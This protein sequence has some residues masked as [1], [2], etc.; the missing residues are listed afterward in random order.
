[1]SDT[2][3]GIS[4]IVLSMFLLNAS[5]AFI[6][7]GSDQINF[8]QLMT[9]MG[10]IGAVV[11]AGYSWANGRQPLRRE[12]IQPAMAWR[13]VGDIF[14]GCMIFI[15]L[16][17]TDLSLVATITQAAPILLAVA[18]ALVLGERVGWRRWTSIMVGF[19]GVLLIVNP[20]GASF[21][22]N[23][24][25]AVG[26]LIGLTIRDFATRF[27]SKSINAVEMSTVGFLG[28]L[29]VGL[30]FAFIDGAPFAPDALHWFYLLAAIFLG[31][32]G[33]IS[34]AGAMRFGDMSAVAPFR[35][36]RVIFAVIVG[37]FAFGEWPTPM[38]WVGILLVIGSGL[39]LLLRQRAVEQQSQEA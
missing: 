5:D 11:T 10:F 8:G 25:F 20:F 6:K 18:A 38:M 31:I 28:I 15:A 27:V 26:A 2:F 3:K 37:Y 19:I 35:Y 32:G 12:M 14:G 1:M 22:P 17:R 24:G 23:T 16:A 9:A 33:L 21:D 4:L 13:L 7:V 29:P 34:I 30:V 39:F 36:S